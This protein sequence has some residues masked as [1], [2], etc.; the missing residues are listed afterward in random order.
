[1]R[2]QPELV[3]TP[4]QGTLLRPSVVEIT[5]RIGI[6][7]SSEHCQAELEVRSAT[8]DVLLEL[9]SWPH[10]P[11]DRVDAKWR[12][13]GRTLTE[14]IRDHTGPF[15]GPFSSFPVRSGNG[16][17]QSTGHTQDG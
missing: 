1:M 4:A 5:L 7:Y 9:M 11:L 12:A 16:N 8:D 2:N 14:V 10:F 3:N 15:S 13:I 6:V 17:N